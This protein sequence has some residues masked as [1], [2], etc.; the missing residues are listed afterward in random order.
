VDKHGQYI[1]ETFE[2]SYKLKNSVDTI[3]LYSIWHLSHSA[4]SWHLTA[5]V[6]LV[7]ERHILS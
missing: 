7:Q 5:I 4:D 3:Y 2:Q 6:L 1:A